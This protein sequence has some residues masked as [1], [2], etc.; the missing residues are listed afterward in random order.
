MDAHNLA[1][2]ISLARASRDAAAARRVQAQRQLDAARAQLDVLHGYARDYARRAQDQLASGCDRMAQTNAR[3]FGGRLEEAVAAQL[4]EL[5]SREA[6]F[7]RADEHW[8]ELASKVQRLELLA[9]RREQ[10]ERESTQ[11]REQKTTD[12][13]ARVVALRRAAMNADS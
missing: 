7:T 12:E 9:E 3:A 6:Q 2:L 13:I 8:R 4:R 1:M 11:R 5:Q 10:A